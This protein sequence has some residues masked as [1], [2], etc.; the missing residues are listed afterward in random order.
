MKIGLLGRGAP[1]PVRR[2]FEDAGIRV[3]P[4]ARAELRLYVDSIPPTKPPAPPWL[5]I[6][7]KQIEPTEA[8]A[9]VL[10]GA[11]DVA[12]IGPDLPVI[13]QRRFAELTVRVEPAS[14]PAGFVGKSEA[15]RRV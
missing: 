5:W 6:S 3:V 14:T 15:A 8:A 4:A 13:V 12:T 2:A 7:P 10:L 11:Y 9:V 1:A